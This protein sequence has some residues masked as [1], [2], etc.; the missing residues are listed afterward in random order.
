[1]GIKMITSQAEFKEIQVSW[2]R[3]FEEAILQALLY[4]GEE[5]LN[6]ARGVT[7]EDGSYKDRTGNL[8]SSIGYVVFAG[9][10]Q[11]L[12]SGFL[13]TTTDDENNKDGV[14]GKL[15]GEEF[16]DEIKVKY[17]GGYQVIMVAGMEYAGYVEYNYDVLTSAEI[18]TRNSLEARLYALR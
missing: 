16:L 5:G 12:E 3:Q 6:Q 4:A 13:P 10:M 8:R 7:K 18:A 15:K 14:D 11:V 1:M 9:N 17:G 2:I